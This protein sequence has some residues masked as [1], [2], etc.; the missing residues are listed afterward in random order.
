PTSAPPLRRGRRRRRSTGDRRRRRRTWKPDAVPQ[1][2]RSRNGRGRVY[3]KSSGGR[4]AA[5]SELVATVR[6][7]ASRLLTVRIFGISNNHR[8][9]PEERR[10]SDASR[11]MAAPSE[12]AAMVRDAA[13]RAAPHHEDLLTPPT[14]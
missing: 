2:R 12:H 9:H 1:H 10:E 13:R 4:M 8:P 5:P 7:A 14:P 11:R 3:A 6:D